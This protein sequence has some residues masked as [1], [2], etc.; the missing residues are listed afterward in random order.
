MFVESTVAVS[1]LGME[2]MD[3]HMLMRPFPNSPSSSSSDQVMARRAGHVREEVANS[4]S[5]AGGFG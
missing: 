2:R 1:K 5:R 4:K 3:V